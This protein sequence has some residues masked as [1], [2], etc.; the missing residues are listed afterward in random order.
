MSKKKRVRKRICLHCRR[1]FLPD[2]RNRAHQK[3]CSS[4]ECRRA[5]KAERQRRWL[6]KPENM[7]YF[8]GPENV[9]R[10]RQWRKRNPGCSKRCHK[11]EAAL[12]DDCSAQVV[13]LQEDRLDLNLSALQDDCQS[14][15]VLLVGLI[16]SLTDSV[17][18]DDI[19]SSIRRLHS[20]GKSIFAMKPDT[21]TGGE[22]EDQE[23]VVMPRAGASSA[24]AL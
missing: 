2:Y 15:V 20:R 18:Q 19:A 13:V 17:L 8:S 11:T 16:A 7:A 5:S 9:E 4:P 24:R 6:N 1:L 23:A 14:Q 21:Q 3:F 10:V 22:D 12:Q